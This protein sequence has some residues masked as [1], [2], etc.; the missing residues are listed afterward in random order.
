MRSRM[1]KSTVIHRM[2]LIFTNS[3]GDTDC[4]D[5]CG[6]RSMQTVNNS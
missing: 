5:T 2:V 4:G 6:N 3:Y 1:Y